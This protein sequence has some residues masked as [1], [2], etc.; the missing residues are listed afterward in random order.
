MLVGYVQVGKFSFGFTTMVLTLIEIHRAE[1]LVP[2]PYVKRSFPRFGN[3]ERTMNH[4]KCN[5][6]AAQPWH[7]PLKKY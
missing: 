5:N 7:H 4:N 1:S 6:E 2:I 3:D